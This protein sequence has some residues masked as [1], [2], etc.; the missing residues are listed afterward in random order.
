MKKIDSFINQYSLSKTLRFRLIPYGNTLANFHA[1]AVLEKDVKLAESY[2]RVK[3]YIDM[4]HKFFID[5]ALSSMEKMDIAAYKELYEKHNKTDKEKEQ[6]KT[7][8]EKLRKIIAKRLSSHPDYKK[9][10]GKE[11]ILELLPKFLTDEE[12]RKTVSEFNL[13]TT[14]FVGFHENR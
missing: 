4:Y 7:E 12:H 14:Y 13:F 11:L 3:E 5:D 2:K 1:R 10:F 9:L 6:L 8:A